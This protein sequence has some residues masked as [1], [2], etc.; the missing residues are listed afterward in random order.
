MRLTAKQAATRAGV[1][2]SLI[3]K[4]TAEEGR[5]PHYR[6]GGKGRGRKILIDAV[7]LDAFM[8]SLKVGPEPSASAP[9]SS[10][11][12]VEPFS[13]LDPCRLAR[14]WKG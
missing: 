9:A 5:L 11:S 3:Y 4:W 13:E 6:L 1:S 12:P 8:Q 2:L 10:R 14:A 7:D